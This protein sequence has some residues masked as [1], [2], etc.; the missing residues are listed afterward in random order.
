V[1]ASP[2]ASAAV[3]TAV[4][5]AFVRGAASSSA[6]ETVG[7]E[8]ATVAASETVAPARVPSDGVASTVTASPLAANE[9]RSSVSVVELVAAVVLTAV[10]FTFQT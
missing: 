1:S 10:P 9:E 4:S 2:S 5:V 3:A 6:T 8:L 7:A